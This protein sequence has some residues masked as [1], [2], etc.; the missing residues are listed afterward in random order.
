MGSSTDEKSSRDS[1]SSR[2]LSWYFC[3]AIAHRRS[4]ALG[5]KSAT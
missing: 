2:E 5:V 4:L 3:I 1:V